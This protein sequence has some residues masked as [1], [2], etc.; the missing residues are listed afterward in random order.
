MCCG[1]LRE[2]SVDYILSW[3]S[4]GKKRRNKKPKQNKKSNKKHKV[5]VVCDKGTRMETR[6]CVH[7]LVKRMKCH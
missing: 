4:N 2:T 1:E 7:S 6:G 5:P 3:L